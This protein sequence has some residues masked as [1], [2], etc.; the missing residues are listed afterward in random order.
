LFFAYVP[1]DAP[2]ETGVAF[3][4]RRNGASVRAPVV[5]VAANEGRKHREPSGASD[6]TTEETFVRFAKTVFV[7]AGIWGIVV[8]T[9]LYWLVDVTGRHYHPPMDYPQ[10]FYGFFS[11][12][13]AWQIAFLIIGSNPARFRSLMIPSM[14]EKF[15]YVLT[16]AWLYGQARI[17]TQ[18]AQAAVPDL[19]LGVLFVVAFTKTRTPER[20]DA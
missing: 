11:V 18:D 5:P 6:T 9:P 14:L 19:L 8:L 20:G 12:A 10:F 2:L 4:A 7:I 17:S 3:A 15:G 13:M 16:L 1:Q